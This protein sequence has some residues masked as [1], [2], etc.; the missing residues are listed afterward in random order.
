M[1]RAG[2]V[3]RLDKDTTGLMVVAK[4]IPAQTHLVSALQKRENFTYEYEAICNGSM[5]AGG[6][7][8]KP[9]VHHATKQTHI[10]AVGK[11]AVITIGLQ[12]I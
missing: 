10:C 2:I 3:H 7:V 6:M 12:K 5:T 11:P 9:I 1:P 8:E 4:T